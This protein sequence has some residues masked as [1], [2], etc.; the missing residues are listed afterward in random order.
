MTVQTGTITDDGA[1]E[2]AI[3]AAMLAEAVSRQAEAV[4]RIGQTS[5]H[6]RLWFTRVLAQVVALPFALATAQV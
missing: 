5:M 2:I 6:A 4:A 3:Q 1:D